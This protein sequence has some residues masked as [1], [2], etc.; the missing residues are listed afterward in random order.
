MKAGTGW[1]LDNHITQRLSD[2]CWPA[3]PYIAMHQNILSAVS[4]P[5][6]ESRWMAGKALPAAYA[7]FITMNAMFIVSL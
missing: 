5:H 2:V 3:A 6:A 1:H 4:F 7:S